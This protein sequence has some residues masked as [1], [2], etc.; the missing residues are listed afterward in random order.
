[1]HGF[2]ASN[3]RRIGLNFA[4][5]RPTI[6]PRSR[7]DRATIV[8][9]ILH[10][11]SSDDRGDD[12]VMQYPRSRLDR[13]AIA[14]RSDRDRG[15]P[16]RIVLTV[17]WRSRPDGDRT[18]QMSPRV[19]KM[20][21]IV[22][23]R[24][25]SRVTRSTIRELHRQPSDDRAIAWSMISMNVCRQMGEDRGDD[26]DRD[27]LRSMKIQRSSTVHVASGKR[28]DRVTY[29]IYVRTCFDR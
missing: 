4:S 10:W 3:P 27:A 25:R 7:L 1:M 24:S 14:V 8:I 13:A 28:V 17:R 21:R 29:A 23:V 19:V 2:L 5:K 16:P 15:V 18:F 22:A 20:K 11:V 26:R 9:L 12:S 6:G